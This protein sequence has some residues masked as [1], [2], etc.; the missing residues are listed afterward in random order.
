MVI[1]EIIANIVVSLWTTLM[2]WTSWVDLGLIKAEWNLLVESRIL[3]LLP[4]SFVCGALVGLER[5]WS[6]KPAGLRTNIMICVGSAL[7]TIASVLCW[8]TIAGESPTTDPGRIAA[9][10]VSGVG[11]IG[12]GVILRSGLRVTGITTAATI[13]LVAAIGVVIGLGFPVLGLIVAVATT[14]TLF[15]LGRIELTSFPKNHMHDE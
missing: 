1:L 4:V 15:L 7:F 8:T 10:V 13:W 11:F 3:L 5:E 6:A 2:G 12:A 9:Q 14:I